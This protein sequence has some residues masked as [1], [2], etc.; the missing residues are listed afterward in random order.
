MLESTGG[1]LSPKQFK[2][3]GVAGAV[4]GAASTLPKIAGAAAGKVTNLPKAAGAGVG[5][6]RAAAPM[7]AR[8]GAGILPQV[9][10]AG[11]LAS[12]VGMGVAAGG[13]AAYGASKTPGG[14]SIIKGA[15][16]GAGGPNMGLGAAGAVPGAIRGA[17]NT[18]G[19]RNVGSG[20]A[21]GGL[22]GGLLGGPVGALGGA[23][24]G[25]IAGLFSHRGMGQKKAM[26]GSGNAAVPNRATPYTVKSGDT[27]SGIAAA[28]KTTVDALRKAN[29]KFMEQGSKYKNGNMIWSGTKVNLK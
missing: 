27:L 21:K 2:A 10:R 28:N 18:P 12:P 4:L 25:G 5:I 7:A 22:I 3:P 20:A 29:P 16:K 13:A 1:N 11:M 17:A 15:V 19:A 6:A 26:S 24:I 8:A 9:A 23:A 14:S